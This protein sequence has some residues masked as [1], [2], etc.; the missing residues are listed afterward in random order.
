[1]IMLTNYVDGDLIPP[2]RGQYLEAINPATAE[3][4]AQVPASD[5]DDVAKAVM[6]AQAAF[7]AWSAL[8]LA[9]RADYLMRIADGIEQRMH[10]LA[11]AESDDNGKPLSL[12]RQIDIPRARDNFRFFAH[13]LTQFHSETYDMGPQGFNYTLRRPIGV[14]GLISP[15]NLPLYL[16]TW[17]IAPALAAGNTAVAKPSELTPLTAFM[18]SEICR[19]ASLPPGVLNIVH[20]RGPEVGEAMVAHPEVPMLSFTGSTRV[21]RRI[22]ELAAPSFKKLSLEMGGKN[23]TLVFA[24]ADY[25]AALEGTLRAAFTNQGQ[26]CLCGS[27]ILVEQSIY[28]RFTADLAARVAA[29]RVGDPR[30][31]H[32]E[33]GAI[34]SQAQWEKDRYYL[35]LAR[36]EG[37]KILAGGEVLTLPGR[38]EK[39]FF[40]SPTL[41]AGLDMRCS[42]NQEEIFGPIAT[43]MPFRDEA[44]ALALANGT[45]YGLSAVLWT[46]QLGRAHRVAA[47]LE[48][49][50]V[51]VN[52]WMVRDLR[53]PFG[54]VK[55]SGVGREGGMEALRFFTEPKN[56]FIRGENG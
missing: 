35:A 32:T 22:A 6:A 51:W 37:G 1:M 19:N 2:G 42:V 26:I 28:E 15:W 53:T 16:F 38:C 30:D 43:I 56:V 13:A 20:G 24:D 52:S 5:A 44:E 34:V 48:A 4:H 17:K 18:L 10:G 23:A 33:V 12:A 9:A 21:G 3:V 54:G 7:P 45:P 49:G 25:E 55:Q 36:D 50:I 40:L 41:I 31:P 39:G 47:A 46:S 29:L 8:P 11:Q 27:R 14:A